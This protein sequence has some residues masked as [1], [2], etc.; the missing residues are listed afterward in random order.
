MKL[1]A[2]D[3]LVTAITNL[4]ENH[5]EEIVPATAIRLECQVPPRILDQFS[6]H[7]RPM[8]FKDD[9]PLV[10]EIGAIHWTAEYEKARFF[11][12]AMEFN[13]ADVKKISF[14]PRAGFLVDLALTVKVTADEKQRGK[15]TGLIKKEVKFVLEK[16]TQVRIE[17]A[18]EEDPED[19]EAPAG[20]KKGKQQDLPEI[21]PLLGA[22]GKPNAGRTKH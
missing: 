14:S 22:D 20:K 12:D 17:D 21:T 6:R 18:E 11:I 19:E 7:L 10:P 15:L 8:L 2:N 4:G 1:T 13:A 3:A 16:M 9:I 5:G